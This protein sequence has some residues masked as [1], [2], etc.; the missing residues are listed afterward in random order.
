[1]FMRKRLS[2]F[3]LAL[4][5][6]AAGEASTSL[7]YDAPA[8]RFFE[9]APL[10][11][12]R[13][14][15]M[16]FGGVDEERIV[17]NESSVWSGSPQNADR[18]GAAAVLPEIRRLLREGKNPEAE[19]LVSRHFTCV[20]PG[21]G[22]AMGANVQFGCY[23]VLGNL[24][25]LSG[26]VPILSSPS[27]HDGQ[28]GQ[29]IAQSSDGDPATKWC[30]EHGGKPVQ[31]QIELPEDARPTR[32]QFTSA[33]DM[34]ERD[35]RQ[36]TLEGSRDRKTWVVL[37]E[38]KN[39]PPISNRQETKAYD[40]ARPGKC[41][42]F[43][44]TFPNNPG[45]PHFQL[46]EIGLDGVGRK[47][48]A[49]S[50]YRR[51]LD[52]RNA[53]ATVRYEQGGVTFDRSHFISAPDE[54][55]VSKYTASKPGEVSFSIALDRPERA[56]TTAVGNDGLLMIGTLNDGKGGEGLTHVTRVKVA[57]QGG[58]V[59]A[60][61]NTLRIEDADEVTLYV[62]AATNYMGFAGRRTADPLAATMADLT[63]AMAKGYDALLADHIKDHRSWFDRVSLQLG[64]VAKAGEKTTDQRLED[65][66]KGQ[67]DPALAALY[68]N[69]GRY[70]LIGSSCPGGLPANLQGI[71]AEEIQ[72]PWNGD[73]HLDI[74]VQM[75]YWPALVGNL[76]ELQDPLDALIAS[77]V[78]P[79]GK[80]ARAYYHAR[81]WVAHV[82]TNP[83]GFTSPGEGA[84]WGATTGGS[85]W[86]C[87]HLWSRYEYTLDKDYLAKVYPILKGS[88][89]F[90]LDNL[91][92]EPKN[93]WLVTGPSNSPENG[94]IMA[95]GRRAHVCM[96]PT[97]D[98]QQLRE[99]FGNTARAAE[100]LG[101]DDDLRQ[102][103]LATRAKLA[104]NQIGP[105]G[106]LQEWL[107]PYGETE[108][109]HRHV[110][111]LYGLYP[112]HEITA[113]GTPALADATRKSLE[114][115]GDAGTGWSL[116]WKINLWARLQDGDRAHKLLTMLLA[117]T[118][119]SGVTHF[120]GGG[121]GSS[122]NL[123]CFHPPFQIDGNFGGAAGI[124]EML[125][126]SHP[127]NGEPGAEPVIRLLPAL[128]S[129]WPEG[130]VKGLRSR[131]AVAVDVRWK[132]G[133]I[134]SAR[135]TPERD[136]A[137]AIRH[138]GRTLK[139][140]ARAGVPLELTAADFK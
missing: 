18:E 19:D 113:E 3:L 78:E 126:Q 135:L 20:P 45:V 140:T 129:A 48:D 97:V 71:W 64:D 32:Y 137:L 6:I 89:L 33:N 58:S 76:I 44:F 115:R 114:R 117:P 74:N 39:Q 30:F 107:E 61:G 91:M 68:F 40:I 50:R 57:T 131:G 79:G 12:G 25:I 98:M 118:A 90:Y 93:K 51:A 100:I 80:T 104:P 22:G 16:V 47:C 72:T 21:S 36:W 124:A 54:V 46:A 73:W 120:N 27:N 102:E 83:W 110:S 132:D 127:D 88:A 95:D 14:G 28:A 5:G 105:D 23:Q 43:R 85:S 112:Y 103:L 136:G 42:F 17:L 2:L 41:R 82:I 109:T 29:Q 52:L 123:F 86:L 35:P 70:L 138:A 106:R 1:M 63:K 31:W 34:P 67:G 134:V 4:P 9:S 60:V 37:D 111:H 125:L 92:E 133:K 62:A 75:N 69:Y 94:F 130:E 66:A 13:V 87:Q 10:G 108:P 122:K 121:A 77:L 55:Y 49:P 11:N 26:K 53:V 116:A 8:K 38:R 139:K 84:S 24:R 96:G 81:G 7:S 15:A 59:K 65:F 128:P 101:T 99:L 119:D 56:T